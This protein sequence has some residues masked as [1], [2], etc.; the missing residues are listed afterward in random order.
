M[1][2]IRDAEGLFFNQ[3]L[4]NDGI[5]NYTAEIG[6]LVTSNTLR[7]PSS[8]CTQED[9]L[10]DDSFENA[11]ASSNTSDCIDSKAGYCFKFSDIS[12]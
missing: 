2:T 4:N 6:D 11:V 7:C 1:Q 5:N 8:P 10:L 9:S 3:D 12:F